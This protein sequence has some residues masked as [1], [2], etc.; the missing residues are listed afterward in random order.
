MAELDPKEIAKLDTG[1][2]H[3]EVNQL[4]SQRFQLT[5]AAVVAFSAVVSWLTARISTSTLETANLASVS[6]MLLLVVLLMLYLYFDMLLGMMRIFTVYLTVKG[7][8]QWEADWQKYR[9][10]PGSKK[11]LGYSKAGGL[12]FSSL[13][14]L[15]FVYPRTLVALS[16]VPDGAIRPGFLPNWVA[17]LSLLLT[18][19]Y[20]G[21]IWVSVH[22]R[23]V[24]HDEAKI[25]L[26]WAS[27]LKGRS[28]DADTSG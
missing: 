26:D 20:V 1:K 7:Y 24:S 5:A 15:S 27:A 2:L 12:V 13:G 14:V 16:H 10:H 17:W 21:A 8:S 19:G 25:A 22:C 11:Y 28:P 6:C 18:A 4:V 3:Q 23:H 9:G